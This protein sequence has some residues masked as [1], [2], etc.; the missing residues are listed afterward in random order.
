MSEQIDEVIKWADEVVKYYCGP[1]WGGEFLPHM[2]E[3]RDALISYHDTYETPTSALVITEC[4]CN[5]PENCQ[6]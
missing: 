4:E 2:L 1:E 6:A 3:L 5:D